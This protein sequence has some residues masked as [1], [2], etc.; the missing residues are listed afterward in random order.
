MLVTY[1]GR[2]TAYYNGQSYFPGEV[3]DAPENI[4]LRDE[5]GNPKKDK[6]GNPITKPLRVYPENSFSKL[7]RATEAE[8]NA[9][10]EKHPRY[11]RRQESLEIIEGQEAKRKRGRPKGGGVLAGVDLGA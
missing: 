4:P 11:K 3:F 7:R 6:D 5:F 1:I 8:Y 9:Y 10:V 2:K